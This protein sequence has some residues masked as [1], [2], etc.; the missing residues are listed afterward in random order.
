MRE[1]GGKRRREGEGEW[2]LRGEGRVR[3]NGG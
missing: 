1:S 3:E 2:G